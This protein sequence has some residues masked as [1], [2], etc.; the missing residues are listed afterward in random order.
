MKYVIN[1]AKSF[2]V[3]KSFAPDLR[4]FIQ[5]GLANS[6]EIKAWADRSYLISGNYVEI[7]EVKKADTI[8]Y[9]TFKPEKDG[10]FCERIFGPIKDWVCSCGQSRRITGSQ[11]ISQGKFGVPKT[12]VEAKGF[13]IL[14]GIAET[15]TFSKWPLL[16]SQKGWDGMGRMRSNPNNPFHLLNQNR[17]SGASCTPRSP[18]C[19]E[20]EVEF[21]PSPLIHLFQNTNLRI[22]STL[23]G[24]EGGPNTISTNFQQSDHNI[25][26]K[27]GRGEA[28]ELRI[29]DSATGAKSHEFFTMN[30]RKGGLT[31]SQESLE[32]GSSHLIDTRGRGG[33]NNPL[34]S[35]EENVRPGELDSFS[36]ELGLANPNFLFPAI[37]S[38]PRAPHP[39]SSFEE[40]NTKGMP[41]TNF[42]SRR[43]D[44]G[45]LERDSSGSFNNTGP[46]L[47]AKQTPSQLLLNERLVRKGGLTNN[48]PITNEVRLGRMRSIPTLLRFF[49]PLGKPVLLGSASG[50]GLGPPFPVWVQSDLGEREGVGRPNNPYPFN[51][52][53][54][55]IVRPDGVD[56][57]PLTNISFKHS[58][59]NEESGHFDEDSKKTSR[60]GIGYPTPQ[61]A[62][63][64]CS[65]C[66]VEV[67]L[68]RIRRYR[69]GY[70]GLGCPVTHIWFLNSRPNI[71]ATLFKM[72]TKYIKK[73]SYYKGYTV[74]NS[75]YLNPCLSPGGDFFDNEW[76]FLH[77]WLGGGGVPLPTRINPF[78]LSGRLELL[79]ASH[80][81]THP[82]PSFKPSKL[83]SKK[84]RRLSQSGPDLEFN[85]NAALN[86]VARADADGLDRALVRG[87]PSTPSGWGALPSHYQPSTEKTSSYSA[88]SGKFVKRIHRNPGFHLPEY[89]SWLENTGAK[90]LQKLFEEKNWETEYQ[91]LQTEIRK[92]PILNT[93]SLLA[94]PSLV[95]GT[96]ST[97]SGWGALPPYETRIIRN[98]VPSGYASPQAS[99]F[100][101]NLKENEV[102][103][104]LKQ[105]KKRVRSLKLLN[106]LRTAGG[107][108]PL[109]PLSQVSENVRG[110]RAGPPIRPNIAT[111][112]FQRRGLEGEAPKRTDTF[113]KTCSFI[114]TSVPVL[115]PELRPIVQLN[116]GQLASSDVNDLYRRLISRNNRLKYY[117][118]G[119]ASRN[120]PVNPVQTKNVSRSGLPVLAQYRE[121]EGLRPDGVPL[122]NN[123]S[124][125]ITGEQDQAND[126]IL[127]GYEA[128]MISPTSY[129]NQVNLQ[130]STPEKS[131]TSSQS[132]A[133]VPHSW[134]LG[135][136]N[137]VIERLGPPIRPNTLPLPM[138]GPQQ[139]PEKNK[140]KIQ[141]SRPHLVEFLVRSEQH[142]VQLAVDALLENGKTTSVRHKSGRDSRVSGRG[143]LATGSSNSGQDLYKSLSDRIG[144]KQGRF[145]Q[146]LLGKRVDYS[147]RSVIVVGPKNIALHQCGLPYEIAQELFQPFLIRHILELQLAK[148]IRGAK[149]IIESNK[150]LSRQLLENIVQSHPILLNRAPTLHRLGIQAFQP[151][152]VQG[153]AVQLHPLVCTA[154][155]AD[156]DGDQMA[157]HVPLSPKARIEARLLMLANTN[158]LSSAT[159]QP[160][161]LPSQDM[162]LG[163]YYL[164]I[165]KPPTLLEQ[166]FVNK[167]TSWSLP[168]SGRYNL[169]KKKSLLEGGP[170]RLTN[171]SS[172]A[173]KAPPLSGLSKEG[174][175]NNIFF[176]GLY[177]VIQAYEQNKLSIHSFV[178]VCL[179]EK[180][181]NTNLV[182]LSVPHLNNT[183]FQK[184][185]GPDLIPLP[186]GSSFTQGPPHRKGKPILSFSNKNSNFDLSLNSMVASPHGGEV[187]GRVVRPPFPSPTFQRRDHKSEVQDSFLNKGDN[188]GQDSDKVVTLHPCLKLFYAKPNPRG[189]TPDEPL[190]I[191]LLQTGQTRKLYTSSQ[192][193]ED[194]KEKRR[195][196]YIR[197]TPGRILVN[198][199]LS[200]FI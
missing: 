142:L 164:T 60:L 52:G 116:A 147:G 117:L 59:L 152:L 78:Q 157:I 199:L 73:I 169:F 5:I 186:G 46:Q 65:N 80:Q 105:R 43:R 156:F 168:S 131:D 75:N 81:A 192:W 45:L 151:K 35:R 40:L 42:D 176:D 125:P 26:S 148:T 159:G 12:L 91:K 67:T 88:G 191:R 178:W 8:N 141:G 165:E 71:F 22:H 9:R 69:M 94:E 200:D 4:S 145:R 118:S 108:L 100:I 87:T 162:I 24:R 155:N 89:P 92:T 136:T 95:R 38:H 50:E 179:A 115:P 90:A 140:N 190:G 6:E 184:E 83:D 15:K 20:W 180:K 19:E 58:F 48:Q 138:K 111:N 17:F 53:A 146:N 174:A 64:I 101:F 55:R 110:S 183:N 195:S 28:E 7:G 70:I 194:S 134:D 198:L 56:G 31:I 76:D 16:S 37:A 129:N 112:N 86:R 197:T 158:W 10:L 154:F 126:L 96:P 103:F 63:L 123:S 57:V 119:G 51:E 172:Y 170:N 177:S 77:R 139:R 39:I 82:F 161:I 27:K 79:V 187:L 120:S 11:Q 74:S 44:A 62:P 13:N 182:S 121:G 104:L 85:E 61:S 30:A 32:I 97:P 109:N 47:V 193:I 132:K 160:S 149:T 130:R 135:R 144:G 143:N 153:R 72:P 166:N 29:E 98:Q 14:G 188:T 173:G 99:Q 49:R 84:E 102:K 137:K 150:P 133:G 113:K 33:P 196:I 1:S 2:Q 114:L 175:S 36:K 107:I 127:T 41:A 171:K 34:F 163:F 185:S 128:T 66:Q 124:I 23:F 54:D 189:S 21:S 106:I 68:S 25:H 18:E 3:K 167:N 122:T 93:T 181:Q